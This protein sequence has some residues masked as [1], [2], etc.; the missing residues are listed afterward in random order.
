MNFLRALLFWFAVAIAAIALSGLYA[1]L[2]VDSTP[3]LPA[4]R[5]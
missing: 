1:W 2:N 5:V 3:S 4:R